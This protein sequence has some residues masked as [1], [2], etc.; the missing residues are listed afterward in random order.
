M[1]L[2]N[3]NILILKWEI[4][5]KKK[6]D[7]VVKIYSNNDKLISEINFKNDANFINIDKVNNYIIE[8]IEKYDSLKILEFDNDS[9][10]TISTNEIWKSIFDEVTNL[11]IEEFDGIKT[12]F[13]NIK[14]FFPN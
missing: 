2:T 4:D 6:L 10:N 1:E 7:Y 9:K 12:E 5:S 3:N 8:N 11:W 14:N 13:K